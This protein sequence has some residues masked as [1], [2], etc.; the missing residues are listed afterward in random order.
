MQLS[1]Y[2]QWPVAAEALA[3]PFFATEGDCAALKPAG[4]ADID[5]FGAAAHALGIRVTA[6]MPLT[7]VRRLRPET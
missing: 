4:S 6:H 1:A 2:G 3:E 5:E 7:H